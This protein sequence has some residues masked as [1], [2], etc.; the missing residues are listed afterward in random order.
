[1]LRGSGY[2]W[3]LRASGALMLAAGV[4]LIGEGIDRL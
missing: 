4:L 2:R 1:M 3:A